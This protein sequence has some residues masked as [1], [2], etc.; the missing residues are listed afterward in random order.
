[1]NK[2]NDFLSGGSYLL[3]HA[4]QTVQ[5]YLDNL[6]ELQSKPLNYKS[7]HPDDYANFQLLKRLST[8][9]QLAKSEIRNAEITIDQIAAH[10]KNLKTDK[11]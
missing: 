9:L 11:R 1:M 5:R 6:R 8:E 10:I 2:L 4:R 3:G 7:L